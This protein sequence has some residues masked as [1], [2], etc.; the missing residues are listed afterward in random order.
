ML[1]TTKQFLMAML[2]AAM[3]MASCSDSK[4]DNAN[5][6]QATV[7]KPAAI[8]DCDLGSSTDDLFALTMLYDAHQKG[9]IDFKAVMIDRGGLEN[10]RLADIMNTYYGFAN[11]PIGK[12]HDAPK[13]PQVFIPYWKMAKPEE[14]K[15]MPTFKRTYT[16]EQLEQ[17]PDAE[18]LYRQILAKEPDSSVVVF[19]TKEG[20]MDVVH[21]I[22]IYGF[23]GNWT[24]PA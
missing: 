17:L 7:T 20:A 3:L 23:C 21:S 19:S 1:K 8:L 4:N 5:D 11:M 24:D 22:P 10:L 18:T 6:E 13:S 15:E 9:Q 12:V 2:P 14:Y 16:D